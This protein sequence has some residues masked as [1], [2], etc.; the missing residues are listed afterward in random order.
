MKNVNTLI[1]T[2][3]KTYR[4]KTAI[5]IGEDFKFLP[6]LSQNFDSVCLIDN[7]A[8]PSF[9]NVYQIR[10]NSS[11]S[12]LNE[13]EYKRTNFDLAYLHNYHT[14][15]FQ[16]NAF[17]WLVHQKIKFIVAHPDA[18]TTKAGGYS[19]MRFA[20]RGIYTV[21]YADVLLNE[22]EKTSTDPSEKV[23]L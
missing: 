16:R 21:F 11:D 13:L 6:A 17:V 8:V 19:R 9:D 5:Q 23:W 10:H 18:F 15:D 1:D 2:I 4:V 14:K 7:D 20:D 22:L 12:Y 3:A